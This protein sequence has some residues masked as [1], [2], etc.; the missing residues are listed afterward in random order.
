MKNAF[1]IYPNPASDFITIKAEYSIARIYSQTGLLVKTSSEKNID[2]IDLSS[3]IYFVKLDESP[4]M[5]KF[6]ISK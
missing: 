2:L 4:L 6:V 5:V 1:E 3:G